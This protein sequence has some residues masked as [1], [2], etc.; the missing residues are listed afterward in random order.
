MDGVPL[1]VLEVRLEESLRHLL[2]GVGKEKTPITIKR[3]MFLRE[4]I[5]VSLLLILF[6]DRGV[7]YVVI[8]MF[9]ILSVCL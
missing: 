1:A 9:Q 4:I 7:L 8:D 6:K 2:R 3:Q 5:S